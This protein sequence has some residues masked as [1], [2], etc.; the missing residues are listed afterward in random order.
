MCACPRLFLDYIR[1]FTSSALSPSL[2]LVPMLTVS[3]LGSRS[4]S[5]RSREVLTFKASDR[6]ISPPVLISF[7]RRS[8]RSSLGLSA[9]NSATATA[10]AAQMTERHRSHKKNPPQKPKQRRTGTSS[11]LRRTVWWRRGPAWA[12][13]GC[14]SVRLS[15]CGL[16]RY[17]PSYGRGSESP[18]S[19]CMAE[20]G[21][22]TT[23]ENVRMWREI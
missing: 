8:R 2:C 10:P 15:A 18:D 22:E 1:P 5:R 4:R 7:S 20:G 13:S 9:M 6:A 23:E 16:L 3:F 17:P 11:H 21:R 19:G 14:Q 12:Q